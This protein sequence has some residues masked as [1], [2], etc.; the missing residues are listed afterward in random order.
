MM[1]FPLLLTILT[2]ST[3]QLAA[4][5]GNSRQFLWLLD[6][7]RGKFGSINLENVYPFFNAISL[8]TLLVTGILMWLQIPRR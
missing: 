6:L 1:A 4:M 5:T 3:F 2:G 7:H 8:L